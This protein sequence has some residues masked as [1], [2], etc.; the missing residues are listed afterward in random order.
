MRPKW[1]THWCSSM[2]RVAPVTG[3]TRGIGAAIAR[4][5]KDDGHRVAAVYHADEEAADAFRR[6]TGIA[7]YRWDVADFDA[8]AA[9]AQCVEA[10]LGPID[11][12]VNNAGVTRDATLHKMTRAQWSEVMSTNLDSLFNMCRHVVEGMRHRRYGRIVNLS[13]INGQ[14]GQTG[15]TNYAASKKPACWAS[16]VR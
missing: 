12:L 2:E 5:L 7:V 3:G 15:Q 9:G 14:T 10:D 1:S 13:S 6:S 4:A 11:I 16:R 8:C